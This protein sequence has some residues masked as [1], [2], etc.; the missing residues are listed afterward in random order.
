[1][2]MQMLD[3]AA[4]VLV[5]VLGR[6]LFLLL[7]PYRECRWCRRGGLVA[8]SVPVRVLRRKPGRKRRRGGRCWRCKGSK[9]TRRLGSYHVYKVRESL[10]QAWAE[11]RSR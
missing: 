8:G 7:W 4:L 3:V 11:W 2:I 10:G 5:T 6:G 1:M 9:L